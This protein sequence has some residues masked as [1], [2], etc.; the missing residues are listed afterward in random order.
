MRHD[1]VI[2]N[3]VWDNR[4]RPSST[5]LPVPVMRVVDELT[6]SRIE[7]RELI[8]VDTAVE[9]ITGILPTSNHEVVAWNKEAIKKNVEVEALVATNPSRASELKKELVYVLPLVQQVSLNPDALRK[10]AVRF[11][12]QYGWGRYHNLERV[13]GMHLAGIQPPG[14]GQGS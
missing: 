5:H 9:T 11:M 6:C 4:G 2:G 12:K 7:P 13:A 1:C 10:A 8:T 3:E 14:H